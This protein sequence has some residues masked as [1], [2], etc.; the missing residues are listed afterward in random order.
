MLPPADTLRCPPSQSHKKQRFVG[1][2]KSFRRLPQPPFETQVRRNVPPRCEKPPPAP[3]PSRWPQAC[4]G[5]GP[6][7]VTAESRPQLSHGCAVFP[8]EQQLSQAPTREGTSPLRLVDGAAP[9]KTRPWRLAVPLTD[10]SIPPG[11]ADTQ[12]APPTFTGTGCWW[13]T[14]QAGG[15]AIVLIRVSDQR[16]VD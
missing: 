9:V 13:V 6:I 15:Q 16:D 11:S 14:R 12:L 2:V 3:L 1:L 7:T 4:S 5:S 10:A 8:Q